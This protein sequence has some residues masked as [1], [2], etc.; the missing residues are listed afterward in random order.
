VV[1]PATGEADVVVVLPHERGTDFSYEQSALS[2]DGATLYLYVGYSLYE[3]DSRPDPEE[4]G[5][6]F[7]VDVTSGEVLVERDVVPDLASISTYTSGVWSRGLAARPDGGASLVFDATPAPAAEPD[8]EAPLPTVLSYDDDLDPTGMV[9]VTDPDPSA[10]TRAVAA[11]VDGTVFLTVGG[12]EP[13]V[14]AV[15]DGAASAVPVADHPDG[16]A[17]YGLSVEPAQEWAHVYTEDAVRPVDLTTG[18]AGE[19]LPL[20]CE[21]QGVRDLFQ[22]RDGVVAVLIGEC[23]SPAER[24]QFLWLAT[25]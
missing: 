3:T 16:Y 1:D 6:L 11:G 9:Q 4:V 24:T 19:G 17:G 14:V 7:A 21:G 25:A 18:E 23:D 2:P 20:E 5:R 12:R 10:E 13:Q 15:G 22:G 8:E